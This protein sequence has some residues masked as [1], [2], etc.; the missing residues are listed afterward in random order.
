MGFQITNPGGRL[1]DSVPE[2]LT[3]GAVAKY[4][5]VSKMT[6][7]RWIKEG[8]LATFKLPK[9]HHRIHRDNL[10]EFTA[11]YSTPVT[12]QPSYKKEQL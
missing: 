9:G 11:K 4:C 2:Y 1:E 10:S 12:K 3:T 8:Y 6:V 7:L 5:G